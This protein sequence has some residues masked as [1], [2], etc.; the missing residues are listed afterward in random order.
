M[1]CTNFG[2]LYDKTAGG[3]WIMMLLLPLPQPLKRW[4]CIFCAFSLWRYVA[5]RRRMESNK[6][7]KVRLMGWNVYCERRYLFSL[8]ALYCVVI[9]IPIVLTQHAERY[10]NISSQLPV[11]LCACVCLFVIRPIWNR[12]DEKLYVSSWREKNEIHSI[13][14]RDT[15]TFIYI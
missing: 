14:Q 13:T 12:S 1:Y 8:L 3:E 5:E 7:R 10:L 15:R 4:W 9:F 2:K 6:K 11:Y